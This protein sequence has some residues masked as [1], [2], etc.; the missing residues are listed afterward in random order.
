MN[1]CCCLTDEGWVIF[2]TSNSFLLYI[3]LKL[4]GFFCCYLWIVSMFS[5]NRL[6]W[7]SLMK[8]TK[9]YLSYK[10]SLSQALWKSSSSKMLPLKCCLS[11]SNFFLTF[12]CTW[13]NTAC[14]SVSLECVDACVEALDSVPTWCPTPSLVSQPQNVLFLWLSLS[15]REPAHPKLVMLGFLGGAGVLGSEPRTLGGRSHFPAALGWLQSWASCACLL[16]VTTLTQINLLF[17]LSYEV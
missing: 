10:V 17:L 4:L 3:H 16:S 5:N 15:P 9:L 6:L 1:S 12:T 2:M 14:I 7:V 8:N 11:E 13:E